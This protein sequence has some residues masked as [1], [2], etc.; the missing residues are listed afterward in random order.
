[1]LSAAVYSWL[2]SSVPVYP[3]SQITIAE[4]LCSIGL[5]TRKSLLIKWVLRSYSL[6]TLLHYS[7]TQLQ[8]MCYLSF[9]TSLTFFPLVL[10]QFIN[11]INNL[12]RRLHGMY[13]CWLDMTRK[14]SGQS[15]TTIWE[16]EDNLKQQRLQI[17]SISWA[18]RMVRENPS[19]LSP[20]L[21]H[22]IMLLR[23]AY[24]WIWTHPC[25]I[26]EYNAEIFDSVETWEIQYDYAQYLWF[27]LS[28][29]ISSLVVL[30]VNGVPHLLLVEIQYH[31]NTAKNKLCCFYFQTFLV[32]IST[33]LTAPC[34]NPTMLYNAEH[35]K[36]TMLSTTLLQENYSPFLAVPICGLRLVILKLFYS[37][38]LFQKRGSEL[39]VSY[40]ELC[41]AS[42]LLRP[43]CFFLLI[44]VMPS[45]P[46][47]NW[48]HSGLWTAI[49]M[50]FRNNCVKV[51]L[52]ITVFLWYVVKSIIGP[53]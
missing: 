43:S 37:R 17:W 4:S 41:K 36:A 30:V 42:H 15:R 23:I 14:S 28:G 3:W 26:N 12:D 11:F 24:F 20:P 18:L 53:L 10:T 45:C 16:L 34:I 50:D 13:N 7:V 32:W 31:T 25:G 48:N 33:A 51:L 52:I 47:M 9:V 27:Y 19:N 1:M 5:I 40:P 49:N 46:L 8:L 44:M 39:H 29:L 6:L 21:S 2:T 22:R 38:K 35:Q